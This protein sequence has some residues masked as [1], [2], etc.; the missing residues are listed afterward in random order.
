M[1]TY[2]RSSRFLRGWST[3]QGIVQTAYINITWL[4]FLYVGGCVLV[5][6]MII[7]TYERKQSYFD[8]RLQENKKLL[9]EWVKIFWCGFKTDAIIF[10]RI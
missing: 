10:Q 6:I 3:W 9:T 4:L 1:Q 7:I 8:F 5:H 2:S